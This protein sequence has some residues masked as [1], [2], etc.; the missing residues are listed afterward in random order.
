MAPLTPPNTSAAEPAADET[1]SLTCLT[2]FLASSAATT[3]LSLGSLTLL[4]EL[5]SS[6]GRRDLDLSSPLREVLLRLGSPSEGITRT[7]KCESAD[8][9]RPPEK[10]ARQSNTGPA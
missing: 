9:F 3:A 1:A 4:D 2:T 5:R 6:F 10:R 8:F 7:S